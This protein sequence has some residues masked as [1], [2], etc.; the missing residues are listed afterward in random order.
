LLEILIQETFNDLKI[1]KC[2][3]KI[4][5]EIVWSWEFSDCPPLLPTFFTSEPANKTFGS[6]LR[7]NP[8]LLDYILST[9]SQ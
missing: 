3:P 5:L 4:D 9:S 6:L 2:L 1:L 8:S 7:C